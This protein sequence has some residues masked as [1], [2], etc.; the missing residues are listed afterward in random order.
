L[1]A[2]TTR[3]GR[4]GFR[5]YGTL[6]VGTFFE[7]FAWPNWLT[8][9]KPGPDRGVFFW[10]IDEEVIRTFQSGQLKSLRFTV[11]EQPT[12]LRTERLMAITMPDRTLLIWA[13]TMEELQTAED[14]RFAKSSDERTPSE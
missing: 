8:G 6:Y 3:R 4:S 11:S 13:R 12:V 2:K 9:I 5:W 10:G 14:S 7:D 1:S